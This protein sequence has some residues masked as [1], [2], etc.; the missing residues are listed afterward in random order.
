MGTR[1]QSGA[2]K[3]RRRMGRPPGP[4]EKKRRNLVRAMVTDA[5]MQKLERLADEKDLPL[6]TLV[7]EL[8]AKT[9][10]RRK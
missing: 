1:K 5:E 7:Y 8:L 9:L 6:S 4:P 3:R 2:G 10:K